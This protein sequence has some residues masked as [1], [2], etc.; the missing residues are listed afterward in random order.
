[1]GRC[2]DCFWKRSSVGIGECGVETAPDAAAD[3][4]EAD[5]DFEDLPAGLS[6]GEEHQAVLSSIHEV[7]SR[8][9]LSVS[10]SLLDGLKLAQTGVSSRLELAG[11]GGTLMIKEAEVSAI[12]E[13]VRR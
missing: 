1:M 13:V 5:W 10:D 11:V 2:S 7:V 9:G 4:E 12:V 8:L 3:N 6:G